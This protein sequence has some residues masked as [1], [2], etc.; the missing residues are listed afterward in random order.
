[1]SSLLTH[2]T[3]LLAFVRAV[4]AGSFSAAARNANSTPSA[5]SKSISR[6]E[7]EV[8]A[9]LFRRSTRTLSLTA[10]G[11]AFFN[12]I[13]PLIRAIDDS[14]DALRPS[15]AAR[16]HLRVS[17]PSELGRLLLPKINAVFLT[18]NPDIDL[19]LTLLDNY[20][21]LIGEGYDVIF[22]VGSLSDSNLKART[23]ARM[24]LSLVASPKLLTEFGNPQTIDALRKMPFVRYQFN[25]RTT[26]IEFQDGE[27]FVPNGRIGINSG[28]GLRAGAID[29][30]GVAYL[31]KMTVQ[32]DL[33]QGRLVELSQFRLHD[34]D[35]HALHAFGEI[36]PIRVKVLAD[37]IEKELRLGAS[38]A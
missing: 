22:R 11:E 1:M 36:T 28:F 15:G 20:V 13:A 17:M 2:S 9:T 31:L 29:G 19:D 5:I 14:A 26:P 12:R 24:K 27:R 10:E 18:E 38:S 34:L 4:E 7:T 23:L 6:L 3:H 37:F 16:G 32:A 33:H 30:M 8:N 25:G 21:D 35:L